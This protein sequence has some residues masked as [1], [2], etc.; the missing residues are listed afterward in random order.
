MTSSA[1]ER[2]LHVPEGLAG[3]RVDAGIARMFGISRSKAADLLGQGLV[4]LDGSAAA[5]SERLVPGALLEVT[6]PAPADPLEVRA[7]AVEGIRIIHDDESIVVIDKPVGV[8][9]H[10]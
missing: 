6:L 3:E 4:R 10:P 2:A 9:V 5:K 1:E 8:A 7:E